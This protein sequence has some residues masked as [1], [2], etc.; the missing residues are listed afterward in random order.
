MNSIFKTNVLDE[1]GYIELLDMMPHELETAEAAV[2][3]A[4]RTSYLSDSKGPEKDKKLLQFLLKHKHT[5]P[6][7]QVTFKFRVYAPAVTFWQWV[8]HRTAA[9]N[10]SSGRYTEFEAD[11]FYVPASHEWRLQSQGGN[12][13][14]SDG[15]LDTTLGAAYTDQMNEIV[16]NSYKL[17]NQMLHDG[18]AREQAR[19]VLPCFAAYYTCVYSVSAHNLI[20]FLRLRLAK[21]AQYEI[22]TYARAQYE[23]FKKVM[24]WTA[25]YLETNEGS[26]WVE[27][28][29]N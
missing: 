12:K 10:F 6:F 15:F 11:K 5:S 9:Y 14:M 26:P 22:R 3:S 4:A 19:L 24:P 2:V 1:I 20:H 27:Q 25:E 8:R 13:Q 16:Y 17:Y 21:E 18:V 7:E 28:N 23:M 29:V